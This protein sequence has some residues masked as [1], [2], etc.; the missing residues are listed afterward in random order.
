MKKILLPLILLISLSPLA[1]AQKEL[2]E[3]LPFKNKVTLKKADGTFQVAELGYQEKV[4]QADPEKTYYWYKRD[5]IRHTQ[6]AYKGRLLH[7]VYQE[8]YANK[9][10]KI[11]GA[12]YKGMKRGEWRYLDPGGKLRRTSTWHLGEENG[13]YRLYNE[14]GKLKEKGMLYKGRREGIVVHYTPQDSIKKTFTRYKHDQV[15]NESVRWF[16]KIVVG[17]SQ[18]LQ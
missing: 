9:S 12:F 6:G 3:A 11:L 15:S 18:V 14:Q 13:K 7:G 1:Y 16:S 8:L 17:I 10:L 2:R 4:A 5:S